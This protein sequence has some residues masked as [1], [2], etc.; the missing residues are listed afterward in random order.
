MIEKY[1]VL[2]GSILISIAIL[3]SAFCINNSIQELV[4]RAGMISH[5]VWEVAYCFSTD[6]WYDFLETLSNSAK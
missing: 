3:F 1:Q 2:I 4:D 6:K 5:N